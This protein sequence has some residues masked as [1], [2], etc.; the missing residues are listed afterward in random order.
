M[1]LSGY[2]VVGWKILTQNRQII[3]TLE[4]Q[5]N[6]QNKKIFYTYK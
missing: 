5:H 3:H 2:N 4:T 1:M 6:E